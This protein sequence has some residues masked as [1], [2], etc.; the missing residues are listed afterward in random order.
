VNTIRAK[1]RSL[2]R[3]AL[4]GRAIACMEQPRLSAL[5]GAV[6]AMD[7][8]TMEAAAVAEEVAAARSPVSAPFTAPLPT[9]PGRLLSAPPSKSAR[10]RPYPASSAPILSPAS[11]CRRPD[12]VGRRHYRACGSER[13]RLQR[14]QCRGGTPG[15]S[16]HTERPCRGIGNAFQGTLSGTIRDQ[17][18]KPL[19]AA[20][21]FASAP[22]RAAVRFS[23]TLALS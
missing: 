16:D 6:E 14:K 22:D 17:T 10:S 13:L 2:R 3:L 8:T 4:L 12:L 5:P 21:V 18:G 9:S 19:V 15:R 11:P 20:R 23:P 7:R 1:H